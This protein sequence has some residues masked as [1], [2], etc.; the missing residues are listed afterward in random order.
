MGLEGFE[1]HGALKV[2]HETDRY[3]GQHGCFFRQ[4]GLGF[5]V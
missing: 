3:R 1:V 4:D 5:R 2:R